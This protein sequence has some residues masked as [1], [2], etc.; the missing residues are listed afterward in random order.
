[1]K[2]ISLFDDGFTEWRFFALRKASLPH[3]RLT[4]DGLYRVFEVTCTTTLLTLSLHPVKLIGCGGRV[5]ISLT[6]LERI[7][8]IKILSSVSDLKIAL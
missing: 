2:M 7:W 4:L 1:M 3:R 8:A 5:I 6:Y